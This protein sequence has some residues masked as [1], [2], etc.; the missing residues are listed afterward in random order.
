MLDSYSTKFLPYRALM[1][2]VFFGTSIFY[3]KPA[4][5]Y[6]RL[7]PLL[8]TEY[9]GFISKNFFQVVVSVDMTK[10]ELPINELRKFCKKEADRKKEQITI[11]YLK[12]NYILKKIKNNPFAS[13]KEKAKTKDKNI[14]EST[15]KKNEVQAE[16]EISKESNT[17]L[18]NPKNYQLTRGEF[19][20]F[21]ESMFLYREDYSKPE[22]CTF[23]YRIIEDG[24]YEKIE[25]TNKFIE[26]SETKI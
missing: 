17:S 5:P 6:F 20:P 7:K 25:K 24:L 21:L 8:N 2:L 16:E 9:T 4:D 13:V 26:E 10:D 23:V 15:E 12:E 22:K 11:E 18:Y 14:E 1:L 3:C 19:Y